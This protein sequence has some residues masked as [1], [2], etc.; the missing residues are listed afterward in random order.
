MLLYLALV[1]VLG[2]AANA[3]RSQPLAW[4]GEGHQP[5]QEGVDFTWVDPGSAEVLRQSLPGVLFLDTR[6]A[7]AY[8]AGHIPGAVPISYTDLRRALEG[9][10]EVRLRRADVV[11]LY[12]TSDDAD[13]E[14]LLAQ[15]LR[16]RGFAPPQV[17][18][19]GMPAWEANGLPVER[20]AP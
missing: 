4:W 14:Q 6:S 3:F 18:L 9:G 16:R 11:V 20:G 15:E 1:L 13:V 8:A 7:A 2:T 12:G 10:M 5:P 19:G 17:L